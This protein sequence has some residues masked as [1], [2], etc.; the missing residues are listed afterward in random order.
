MPLLFSLAPRPHLAIVPFSLS[1]PEL[2]EAEG[3][4]ILVASLLEQTLAA[5]G[6]AEPLPS[7]LERANEV[8]VNHSELPSARFDAP[9]SS[10][11]LAASRGWL[12]VIA[13]EPR[14]LR[15]A[16]LAFAALLVLT[17]LALRR[18]GLTE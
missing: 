3:Y 12:G 14:R 7:A 15:V 13:S 2:V 11:I 6:I 17:E 8:L 18:R 1:A 10:S 4:P 9:P 5:T 16:L